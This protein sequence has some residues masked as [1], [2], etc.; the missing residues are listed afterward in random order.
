MFQFSGLPL[1]TLYIHVGVTQVRC[2]GLPHSGI[3]GLYVC[4]RLTEAFRCLLRPSSALSAKASTV[5]P[6]LLDYAKI[7]QHRVVKHD[8][9]KKN[10]RNR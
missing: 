7:Y 5:R 4:L 9:N 3:S 1:P 8:T 2:A 6:L 10:L